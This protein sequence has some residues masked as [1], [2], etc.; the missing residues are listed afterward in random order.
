MS[1]EEIIYIMNW[2]RKNQKR[3]QPNHWTDEL[4]VNADDLVEYLVGLMEN[5]EK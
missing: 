1:N 5:K 3:L 2:I 4:V